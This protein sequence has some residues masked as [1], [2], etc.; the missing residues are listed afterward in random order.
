MARR[1]DDFSPKTIRAVAARAGW[2][3][4]F[5]NCSKLTVGPSEEAPGAI[6]TIGEAAHI[7]AASPGGRRHDPAMTPE[8]RAG[9]GNAMWVCPDHA[10]LID[11]D[12]V[13]YPADRLH[14]MKRAQEERCARAVRLGSSGSLNTGLLAIGP[15]IVCTGTLIGVSA[16]TWTLRLEHFLIGDMHAV[17][18]FIDGFKHRLPEAR[19]VL[20][21]DLGDGRVLAAPPVLT[22][23]PEGAILLCEVAPSAARIDAQR[24]GSAMAMHPETGDT[25]LD[26]KGSIARVSGLDYLPQ[27]VRSIL[28]MQRGESVFY[29]SLGMRFFE[30]FEAFRGSPWLDLLLKLD[31]VRQ[32]SVP[33]QD[34]LTGERQTP[35]RCVKRVRRFELLATDPQGNEIPVCVEFEVQ[36]VGAWR[37]EFSVYMPTADQMSE[38]AKMI[39]REPWLSV[40]RAVDRPDR[41]R[42]GDP[43]GDIFK[44]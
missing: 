7:R 37:N 30:Y 6:T 32:A 3:C 10:K 15:D 13:T 33:H 4:S 26:D 18:E 29:P 2:Q 19:Y 44:I 17:I 1:D 21:N 20:S 38:R 27:M 36:G 25:Y 41:G 22:N 35:L 5:E 8:E 40:E 16:G 12:A 11:R 9:V 39:T 34:T 42:G 28:S 31:V 43:A 14:G 24:L 23:G